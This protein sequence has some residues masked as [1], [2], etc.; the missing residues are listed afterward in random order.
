MKYWNIN[1]LDCIPQ[2]GDLLDF[3]VVA[4]WSRFAKETINEKEYQA[5][6]NGSQSFSKDSV[7]NFIP[8]EQL[9]YEIV[10][11]W[12]NALIDVEALDLKLDAQIDSQVNPPIVILP[13]PWAIPEIIAEPIVVETPIVS[14]EII[15]E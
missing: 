8:Y 14:E 7:T 5:S 4:H 2:D 1:Q 15:T 6:V 12:L 13:L 10:C 11:G 3:V 9:T